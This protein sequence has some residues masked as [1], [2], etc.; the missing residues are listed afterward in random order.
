M[1]FSAL[2]LERSD[3]LQLQATADAKKARKSSTISE[4]TAANERFEEKK[5]N[6]SQT[7]KIWSNIL[8]L[9]T[10]PD[11]ER[12]EKAADMPWKDHF[13][14]LVGQELS[15]SPAIFDQCDADFEEVIIALSTHLARL[16]KDVSKAGN[17]AERATKRKIRTE[18]ALEKRAEI[19]K[20][21]VEQQLKHPQEV[22]AQEA[23][24]KRLDSI[25]V[26]S[27]VNMELGTWVSFALLSTSA[28]L[29]CS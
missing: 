28:M 25:Q 16:K 27:M 22:V 3:A 5:E 17:A 7:M 13:Q 29:G 15:E 12:A 4:L 1:S 14:Q 21:K 6:L 19:L 11:S 8:R 10:A 2:L 20:R 23:V 18:D 24:K 26:Q 9:V